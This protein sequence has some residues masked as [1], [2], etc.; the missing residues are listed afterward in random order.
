MSCWCPADTAWRV[1]TQQ[2]GYGLRSATQTTDD[3]P[4]AG[5]TLSPTR[6]ATACSLA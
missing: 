2:D 3:T 5:R 4:I 6:L 1:W